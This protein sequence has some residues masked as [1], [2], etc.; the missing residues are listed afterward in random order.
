MNNREVGN[1]GEDLAV[2][3]LENKKYIILHRNY[4]IRSGEI[5]I[6]AYDKDVLVCIEVKTRNNTRYGY[7]YESVDYRKQ[8]KIIKTSLHY[9]NKNKIKDTQLRYDIIEVYLKENNRINHIEN[10]FILE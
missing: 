10:A 5:D 9:L 2:S 8:K 7:A 3:Y 4:Q 1:K 6:I